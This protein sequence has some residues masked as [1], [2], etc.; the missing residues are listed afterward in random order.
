MPREKSKDGIFLEK[1]FDVSGMTCSSCSAHIERAVERLDGVESVSVN[2]LTATMKVRYREEVLSALDIVSAVERAGY[3]ASEKTLSAAEKPRTELRL[4]N[5][6]IIRLTISAVFSAILMYLSMGGMIGLPQPP[7]DAISGGSAMLALTQMLLCLPVIYVNFAYFKN[8]FRRI[9]SLSPNMDSLI[10][11]GS[12]VSFLYGVFALYMLVYASASFDGETLHV[13]AHELYFESAATILTLITLG[14]FLEE[15]SKKKT[16]DAVEKLKALVPPTAIVK[17]GEKEKVIDSVLLKIGD[18]AVLKSGCKIPCDGKVTTGEIHVDESAVTGESMPS[19]KRAGDI[20]T[21]GT[22]VLSG[23]AEVVATGVGDSS[24]LAAIIKTVAEVG[25]DKAPIARLADK[26]SGVFV[27][28]VFSVSAITF[29]VWM[30]SGAPLSTA[31]TFAVNVLVISCPCA[32]GLATP[33][34]VMAG[35]GKGA[36]YGVLFKSGQALETLHS[37]KTVIFDKTGTL[38]FGRPEPT[39]FICDGDEKS[40]KNKVAAIE[41]KSSHPLAAAIA[42]MGDGDEKVEDFKSI[43]G[44]GVKAKISDTEYLIGNAALLSDF[45]AEIPSD[46][47]ARFDE[48]CRS[49]KTPMY[50]ASGGKCVGIVAVADKLREGAAPAIAALK[51]L[52]IK[53]VLLTGD[54]SVTAGAVAEKTGIDEVFAEVLPL[55]KEKTVRAFSEKGVCA[56][57]GDGINDAPALARADVGIAMGGGTDVALSSADVVLVKSEPRDVFTAIALS[58]ATIKNVAENLFWAFFYNAACIPLA[59]GAFFPALGIKLDPMIAAAA[60]SLSS[61]F[62]VC[63]ALRLRL[64]RPK[65]FKGSVSADDRVSIKNNEISDDGE[66]EQDMKYT[67]TIEGMSCR[68]CAGR[69]EA[70]IASMGGNAKVDLNAKTASITAGEGITEEMLVEAVKKAGYDPVSVKKEK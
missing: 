50:I 27:P 69:V 36:E 67:M 26:I 32:L 18:I 41:A 64:F 51:K 19:T 54:N 21:G 39:D 68:H 40:L 37:V 14:K 7:F 42:T 17:E 30:I 61:L 46:K 22:T 60:M 9:F 66:K 11:V 43:D 55:D 8:G 70:A 4:G 59:A 5:D 63:N 56:M 62:V 20:V 29:A 38:T 13:Y 12:A 2:L 52:G 3:G 6:Y 23:Y 58:R 47:K 10:A 25:A 31:I 45:G 57:V 48:L 28:A 33:V 16:M 65:P 44:K 24:M 49:G 35:G 34:A 15:K 1:I 53:T